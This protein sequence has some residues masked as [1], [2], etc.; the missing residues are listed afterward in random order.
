MTISSTAPSLRS[1]PL[2]PG[3]REAVHQIF[4]ATFCLGRPSPTPI[5]VWYSELCLD[6]YFGEGVGSSAVVETAANRVVGYALV[7]ADHPALRRWVR[8]SLTRC[9]ADLVCHPRARLGNSAIRRFL[10]LRCRDMWNLS[11]SA[12][13]PA[14]PVSAHVNLLETAQNS[15]AARL[16][17]DH[18]DSVTHER[19]A[20]GWFAEINA[21]RGTRAAALGRVLGTVVDRR[22]N[23]T[24]SW[25]TGREVE[26]LTV[27]RN[28]R[29]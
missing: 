19:R 8:R 26:R 4:S 24:L 1:R 12:I 20:P 23:H 29:R 7:C 25:L 14:M 16:L 3:D 17:R 21:V 18:V 10:R 6:W 2:G 11:R 9:G 28:S 5:P 15:T 22:P 27:V 13:A